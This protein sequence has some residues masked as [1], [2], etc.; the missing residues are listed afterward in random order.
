MVTDI[1][2]RAAAELELRRRNKR[3]S[4]PDLETLPL[5]EILPHYTEKER[6]LFQKAR[7]KAMYGGRAGRKSHAIA[8]YILARMIQDPALQAVVF[9]KYRSAVTYSAQLLL[10]NKI[11]D[12]G[13]DRYFEALGNTIRRRNGTGFIAFTGI[14]DHNATSIKSYENFG[15]A[16]GEESTEIDQYSLDLLIPTLR[17]PGA[18]LLFSWNPDQTTDPVDQMFRVNPPSN[19]VVIP[20]SFKDNKYLSDESRQDEQDMLARDPEKHAWVWLG[21][22]NVHSNAIIFSG[23][24]RVDIVDPS[25]WDGPYYGLDFGFVIDPTASSRNWKSPDGSQI[26]VERQ[27]YRYGLQI[28][29]IAARLKEDMPGIESA[30]I[31]ADSSEQDTIDYLKRH[32]L[33]RIVPV[34]KGPGS[35]ET[36]VKWLKNHE[37]IVHPDCVDMQNEL[38]RY[39]LKT[40]KAGDILD[41]IVDKDNHLIDN[42]RY[43][44]QPLIKSVGR[45][46]AESRAYW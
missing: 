14:Q 35:V 18:E 31:R 38:K 40:N 24:W 26:Y 6:Q 34:E 30:V 45:Q 7:F 3:R 2:T 17:A 21:E 39:R 28:D 23:R 22:Y 42:L 27:S 41:E 44:F 9:R 29:H 37:M 4:G 1:A 10:K 16:W 13:W 46:Y 32:G 15:I 11:R 8:E 36:G 33:P 25:T 43:A 5:A 20:V 19:A 12:M